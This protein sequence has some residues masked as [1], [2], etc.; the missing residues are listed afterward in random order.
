MNE[1]FEKW[2][3]DKFFKIANG[4]PDKVELLRELR[5]TLNLTVDLDGELKQYYEEHKTT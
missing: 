4:N 3:R 1:H 2:V 5:A